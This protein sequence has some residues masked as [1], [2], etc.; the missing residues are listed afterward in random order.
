MRLLC[1]QLLCSAIAPA[2]AQLWSGPLTLPF[3]MA[4]LH[5]SNTGKER[6]FV[7]ESSRLLAAVVMTPS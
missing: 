3:K 1:K 4:L 5:A 6:L 7:G 2:F